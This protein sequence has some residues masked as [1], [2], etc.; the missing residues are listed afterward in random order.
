VKFD[1]VISNGG[2][3]Y[4][5]TSGLKGTIFDLGVPQKLLLAPDVFHLLLQSFGTKQL[6]YNVRSAKTIGTFR[7]RLKTRLFPVIAS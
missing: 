1:G 2:D 6:P 3:V 4:M 5:R 7:T